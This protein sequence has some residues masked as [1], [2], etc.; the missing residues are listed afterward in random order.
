M[1]RE[2]GVFKCNNCNYRTAERFNLK[3]HIGKK[4]FVQELLI[5]SE[6]ANIETIESETNKDNEDLDKPSE[7]NKDNEDL[8]KPTDM[9]TF[10][11]QIDL[12]KLESVFVDQEITLEMLLEV[13]K[14]EVSQ[15]LT[16]INIKAW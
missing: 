6:S 4:H 12:T 14:D 8:D 15:M 10:L 9:K 1:Q 3:R 11:E 13:P 5:T 16:E 2:N 7:T